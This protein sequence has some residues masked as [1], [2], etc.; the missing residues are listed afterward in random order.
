MFDRAFRVLTIAV[1]VIGVAAGTARADDAYRVSAGEVIVKCPLTVGG[2]FEARTKSI[3]GQLVAGENR[4]GTAAGTVRVDLQTLETGIGIRDRHMRDTYLEVNKAPE[5]GVA[6]IEQIRI[7]K[8]EGKTPF[9]ATLVLHGQRKEISGTA[10]LKPQ[11]GRIRIEA[12]FP[13]QVSQFAIA[14][15]TYLGVGVKD[16]LQVTV[17]MTMEQVQVD[18]QNEARR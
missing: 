10:E 11:G 7:E 16:E 14:K 12:Q 3:Q 17:T 9:N 18:S 6:T 2:S 8:L 1:A 5:F 15:P 4:S 13:I